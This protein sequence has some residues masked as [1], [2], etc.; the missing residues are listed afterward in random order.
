MP[1]Y[2]ETAVKAEKGSEKARYTDS[3][4]SLFLFGDTRDTQHGCQVFS[5]PPAI[6]KRIADYADVVLLSHD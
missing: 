6:R 2:T 3:S 5:A 4:D 1:S